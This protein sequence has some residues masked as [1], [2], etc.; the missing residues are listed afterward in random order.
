MD[1][2]TVIIQPQDPEPN[3]EAEVRIIEAQADAT[4]DVIEAQAD[5]EVKVIEARTGEEEWRSQLDSLRTSQEDARR[6][7]ENAL[8]ELRTE[9]TAGLT[10]LTER[11]AGLTPSPPPP[12]DPDPPNPD[13]D[14]SGNTGPEPER[15]PEAEAEAEPTPEPKAPERK[16]A[17]RWI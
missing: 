10:I 17:H 2:E 6:S 7:T 13:P 8:S 5:A 12:P 3:P 16:R 15:E 11:M 9:M 4:V 1:P 14:Q